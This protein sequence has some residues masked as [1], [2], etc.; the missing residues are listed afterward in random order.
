MTDIAQTALL[1]IIIALSLLLLILGIQVF[2]ILKDF[3]HILSRANKLLDSIDGIAERIATSASSVSSVA[4]AIKTSISLINLF[5][6][7]NHG[8]RHRE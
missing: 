8:K 3:R 6:K 1:G 2:F 5:K 7:K 4:A